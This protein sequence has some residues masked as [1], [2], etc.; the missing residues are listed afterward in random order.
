MLFNVKYILLE[1]IKYFLVPI[2]YTYGYGYGIWND[3]VWG[4]TPMLPVGKEPLT[5]IIRVYYPFLHALARPYRWRLFI[6]FGNYPAYV[7][8]YIIIK[9][10]RR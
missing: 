2:P 6:Y 8:N 7:G 4:E 5:S 10:I 3:R 9:N 1:H